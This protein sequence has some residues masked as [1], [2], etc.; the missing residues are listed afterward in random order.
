MVEET[1]EVESGSPTGYTEGVRA[2]NARG[3]DRGAPN[4]EMNVK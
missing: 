1:S 4:G 2:H 3:G